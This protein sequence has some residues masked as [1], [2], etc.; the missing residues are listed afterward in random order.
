M[1]SR[2]RQ[3]CPLVVPAEFR[4]AADG[5]VRWAA[6]LLHQ[7]AALAQIHTS[8]TCARQA[9]HHGLRAWT[10]GTAALIA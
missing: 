1:P 10:K 3:S 7:R 6:A 8:D 5:G 4:S 2:A 9:D